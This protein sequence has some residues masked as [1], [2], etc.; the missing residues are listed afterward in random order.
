MGLDSGLIEAR[1]SIDGLFVSAFT[2]CLC[3]AFW[4]GVLVSWSKDKN[5]AAF[6]FLLHGRAG[7]RGRRRRR[8]EQEMRMGWLKFTLS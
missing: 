7:L 2:S 6:F 8:K 3:K 5:D 4:L 1:T